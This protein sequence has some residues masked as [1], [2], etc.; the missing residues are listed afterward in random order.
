MSDQPDPRTRLVAETFHDEWASGPAHAF[1]LRAA[2]SAR[3]RRTARHVLTGAGV[4]ATAAVVFWF[5]SRPSLPAGPI[6]P[7]P[8]VIATATPAPSPA[9]AASSALLTTGSKISP[10]FDV[11][12]DEELFAALH[13]RPLL[14]LPRESAER[15]IVVLAR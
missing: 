15:R 6:S 12:S 14:I 5:T 1:A 9:P 8:A 3:R 13:D 10:A 11:I 7:A 4:A 2:A